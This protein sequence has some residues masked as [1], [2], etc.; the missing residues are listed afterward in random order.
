MHATITEKKVKNI[1]VIVG[2]DTAPHIDMFETGKKAAEILISIKDNKTKIYKEFKKIPILIQTDNFLTDKEPALILMNK[3][4]KSRLKKEIINISVFSS[5][6]LMDV[7]EAGPSIIVTSTDK[8]IGNREALS[9]AHG[10]WDLRKQFLVKLT[11][12]EEAIQKAMK[13]QGGPIIFVDQ[14]DNTTAGGHG[15][16]TNILKEIIQ[17]GIENVAFGIIRDPSVVAKSIKSGIGEKITVEIGAKYDKE[18]SSPITITGIV[19]LISDGKYIYKAGLWNNTEAN[20]GKTVLLRIDNN[21]DLIVTEKPAYAFDPELFR[22]VGIDPLSKK[23]LVLK[24]GTHF[25]AAYEPISK[26]IFLIDCLGASDVN[27]SRVHY[28]KVPKQI[29]P[30]NMELKYL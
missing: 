19:K 26:D 25:R 5:Y 30:L 3:V 1:D 20:M 18:N 13:I 10:I 11:S 17:R 7:K 24:C 14:A 27:F 23:I 29:Y 21:V 6:S 8:N 16:N 12:I 22:S 2:Y 4:K 9:L 15:D 28:K